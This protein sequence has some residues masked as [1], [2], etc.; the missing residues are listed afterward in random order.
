MHHGGVQKYVKK[1]SNDETNKDGRGR[2]G[3]GSSSSFYE[4][5]GEVNVGV[6]V[7]CVVSVEENFAI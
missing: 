1:K 5:V 6:D 7:M 4:L 3:G 2:G